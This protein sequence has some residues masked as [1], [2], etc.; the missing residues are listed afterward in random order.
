MAAQM[1]KEEI[2]DLCLEHIKNIDGFDIDAQ[3]V[4][5]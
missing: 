3:A 5:F 4:H 1:G 2:V